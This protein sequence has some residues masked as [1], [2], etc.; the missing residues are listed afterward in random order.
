MYFIL[1][2]PFFHFKCSRHPILKWAQRDDLVYITIELPDAKDVK[3]KLEPE[4]KF[5]FS[6]TSGADNIPYE[7]D[8]NL[9]DKVDVNESKASVGSR[10]ILY[11][12]K[13][14]ESKWWSRLVKEEGRTPAFI[15]VDWNKWVDEDEQDEKAGPDMEYDDVN[16][17]SLNIGGG[18]EEEEDYEDEDESDTEEETESITEQQAV[19]GEPGASSGQV[20]FL[21][22]VL[23]LTEDF[24]ESRLVL[25][26]LF[27]IWLIGNP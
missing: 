12:V 15:K 18:G 24:D 8:I 3:L 6:A 19:S 4:G 25:V 23:G 10:N 14:E 2:C 5:H 13:K 11:L 21:G 7:I 22:C 1:R 16:F 9:N 27:E 26:I 20:E 17:S